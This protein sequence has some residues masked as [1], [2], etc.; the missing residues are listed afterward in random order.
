MV[1]PPASAGG[2]EGQIPSLS[3]EDPLG[4]EVASVSGILIWTIQLVQRSLEETTV[5]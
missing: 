3:Q 2:R 5:H 4:E 1:N